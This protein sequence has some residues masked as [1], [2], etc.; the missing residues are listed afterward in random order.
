MS[1]RLDN[2]AE[3]LLLGSLLYITAGVSRPAISMEGVGVDTGPTIKLCVSSLSA[4]R[5]IPKD[6]LVGCGSKVMGGGL[7]KNHTYFYDTFGFQTLCTYLF[8]PEACSAMK[9]WMV[10][11]NFE[12]S[13]VFLTSSAERSS[14][15]AAREAIFATRHRESRT[16]LK[17]SSSILWNVIKLF[18]VSFSQLFRASSMA[19]TEL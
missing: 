14:A 13:K 10:S 1:R 4:A 17:R 9:A 15:T 2:E 12:V 8:F 5:P 18:S 19:D 16:E 3:L 6:E 7:Q 11:S